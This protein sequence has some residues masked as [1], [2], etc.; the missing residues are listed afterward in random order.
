MDASTFEYESWDTYQVTQ[1]TSNN[2]LAL[3]VDPLEFYDKEE[4]ASIMYKIVD[5]KNVKEPKT[6]MV[7]GSSAKDRQYAN[8]RGFG[9]VQKGCKKEA[10]EIVKYVTFA[11]VYRDCKAKI[12]AQLSIDGKWFLTTIVLEHNHD[13]S[14]GKVRS[15]PSYEY[16]SDVIMFDT[17]Y[18]TNR[19]RMQF[20]PFVGVNHHGQSMLL[21]A[22][23]ISSEDIETFVW[24][25]EKWLKCM[26]NCAPKAIITDQDRTMKSAIAKVFPCARHRFCLWDIM[27]NFFKKLRSLG[28]YHTIKSDI[29]TAVYDSQTCIEFEQNWQNVLNAYNLQENA[30]LSSLYNEWMHWVP[31]YAKDTFWASMT[32]TQCSESMNAF[33]DDYV[34]SSTTLK[35]FVN[36]LDNALGR[37]V[38]NEVQAD[39]SSFN[40]VIPCITHYPI[41]KKFQDVYTT[42][43]VKEVQEEFRRKLYCHYMLFQTECAIS[44]YT[45]T[46]EV[47]IDDNFIKEVTFFVYFNENKCEVKCTYGLFEFRGILCRH[48]ITVLTIRK[49]TSLPPIYI[50]DRW[51]KDIKRRYSLIKSS[52]DDLSN[53]PTGQRYE[54]MF[55]KWT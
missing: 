31:V 22:G 15:R 1:I 21:G 42:V 10:D 43:K 6:G 16:F 36:Q 9:I 54:N 5:D 29:Q 7:F 35:E 46:N 25:F 12:N 49:V 30:W 33:F 3:Q 28:Q 55:K 32:T 38:E 19:Y 2:S 37:K 53:N 47:K 24:L 23:L 45:V 50:L 11:C 8:Q 20:A 41:E 4:D 27:K 26:N 17:M 34:H 14:P 48:S 39:F 18:M 13:L 44:T 52:Y 51:R 40:S